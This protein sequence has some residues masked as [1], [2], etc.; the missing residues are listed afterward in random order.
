MSRWTKH[1]SQGECALSGPRPQKTT[2]GRIADLASRIAGST[3]APTAGSFVL[4]RAL[5]VSFHSAQDD[6][7][8]RHSP[9]EEDCACAQCRRRQEDTPEVGTQ[10][11]VTSRPRRYHR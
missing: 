7:G 2:R 10:G 1:A 6:D 11:K 9:V 5:T 4:N 3:R 8:L